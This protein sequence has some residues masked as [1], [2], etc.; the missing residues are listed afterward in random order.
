MH[1][2]WV[3]EPNDNSLSNDG[4]DEVAGFDTTMEEDMQFKAAV[5][6]GVVGVPSSTRFPAIQKLV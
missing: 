6:K 4:A 2:C 3:V 1:H 5:G